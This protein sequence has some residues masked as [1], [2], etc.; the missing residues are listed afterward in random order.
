MARRGCKKHVHEDGHLKITWHEE[1]EL[2]SEFIA[3]CST[4]QDWLQPVAAACKMMK[5]ALKVIYQQGLAADVSEM[6]DDLFR[7]AADG[8]ITLLVWLEG[9]CSRSESTGGKSRETFMRE[10]A[11]EVKELLL[12]PNR[13]TEQQTQHLLLATILTSSFCQSWPLPKMFVSVHKKAMQECLKN[14]NGVLSQVGCHKDGCCL[15]DVSKRI[16]QPFADRLKV[17]LNSSFYQLPNS[18]KVQNAKS[19]AE[20][21]ATCVEHIRKLAGIEDCGNVLQI[22][23]GV[24]ADGLSFG[25]LVPNLIKRPTHMWK[26]GTNQGATKA[27]EEILSQFLAPLFFVSSVSDSELEQCIAHIVCLQRQLKW[28]LTAAL[29]VLKLL[30]NRMT[31]E[32]RF[33]EHAK[34]QSFLANLRTHEPVVEAMF[35]AFRECTYPQLALEWIAREGDWLQP[36]AMCNLALKLLKAFNNVKLQAEAWQRLLLVSRGVNVSDANT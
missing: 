32:M 2:T 18:K 19:P 36:D 10:F 12:S 4:K 6:A 15:Q 16:L 14:Y 28:Q 26:C 1:P 22:A 11:E 30:V 34:R 13:K 23:E 24:C 29:H 27:S 31:T 35:L 33:N 7:N 3:V 9:F 5:V 21:L 20:V 25:E 8:M 17:L